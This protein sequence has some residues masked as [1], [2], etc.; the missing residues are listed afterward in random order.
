VAPRRIIAS[1]TPAS[2][3]AAAAAAPVDVSIIIPVLNKLEFTAQCLDRIWRNTDARITYEV[4]VVDN[5]STDGTQA[6]FADPSRFPRPSRYLRNSTN[7][8]FGPANNQGARQSTGRYLL[9]LNNDTLVQSGWLSEMLK[10]VRDDESVGI[11]GIKQLFPYTNEV[12]HTGIVFTPDR[13]PVHLYPH[14]DA[15]VAVVNKQREYQAVNGACLLVAR[16]LFDACGGFDEEYRNG[17]EDIDLCM[18]ARKQGRTIV[19]CTRA[20]IY[21]YGQITEGRTADDDQNAAIF[22]R[23]WGGEVVPDRDAYM[24]RDRG[25]GRAVFAAARAPALPGDAIYLADRLDQGSALTWVNAELAAALSDLGAPVFVSGERP[26]SKTLS[27]ELGHR[28]KRMT[29]REAPVGGV[30][31]KWSHYWPQHLNLDLAGD[32][33]L[34]LFVINYVFGRPGAE[35]WDYW[36]QTLRGTDSNIVS[37]SEFC[38]LVAG[39]AG[40]R[41]ERRHVWHP[42]YSPEIRDVARPATA[43]DRFRFLTVTNSH[44]LER[45]N[46]LAL[47]K[48]YAGAFTPADAVTLVV[49]DYGATSSDRRL[50]QAIARHP[51][52]AAIEYVTAFTSKRD[53]IAL[54]RSCD[55]FVSA[56]RGEGFGM[57]ILDALAC[58]L[59]VIT[60]LFGGP[61]AYC[62]TDNCFA[63]DFAK[64]PVGDCLDTRSL[65]ITNQPLWAEVDV[66]SL[67]LQLLRVYRDGALRAAVARRGHD[68]V[69]DAFSWPSAAKR[70]MDIAALVRKRT[71]VVSTRAAERPAAAPTERSPYWQG[72]R[73]SVVVP[74]HNRKDKLLACLDALGRQSVLPQEYEVIVVD[75]GS[76]DGTGEAIRSR[77]FPFTFRYLRQEQSGPA[78]A[79]NLGVQTAEGELVLFIGDDIVADETLIEEHL[80]AHAEESRE[81]GL[82]ILGHIDWPPWMSPNALMQYVCGESTLQF[83]FPLISQ[84]R[85][86]DHRFFYTSNIS[87]RRTFLVDAAAAGIVFDRA[88]RH[89]AFEDSEFA[90]RLTPR[91]LRIRYAPRARVWHD[92]WMDLESFA[93]REFRAGQ[94]AVVFYRKHPG[95]EEHVRV[96]WIA[97]LVRDAAALP[98]EPD[99]LASLRKLDAETDVVLH[100]LAGAYDA[101]LAIAAGSEA[102][103]IRGLSADRLRAGLHRMFG[104]IFDVQRTRGKVLEWYSNVEDQHVIEAAQVLAAVQRKVEFLESSGAGIAEAGLGTADAGLVAGLRARLTERASRTVVDAGRRFRPADAARRLIA[105]PALLESLIR[106]DRF[107]QARLQR[108][109][110]SGWLKAYLDLRTRIRRRLV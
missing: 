104:V 49:K 74:T 16:D 65:H 7:R 106:A 72:L 82:A 5:A 58:G 66:A 86:L 19:C 33:N 2:L 100:S 94:M 81:A 44:D 43:R 41:Q 90:L 32:V 50:Q 34:A 25:D 39:Q 63:V 53:L 76:V 26:L 92:H 107:V 28:L 45:Y 97:D 31:V 22:Q 105:R 14:L 36:L 37:L 59:P 71:G 13:Q 56:H 1:L 77:T 62:R 67:R 17:Y 98:A 3:T 47:L 52:A 61:T 35:P 46:T 96:R 38:S 69:V 54:Y 64:V 91:G 11:V 51:D 95:H 18:K 110:R 4:V 24:A 87:L 84:L 10:I 108:P 75:D 9:F 8:G 80:I 40:V 12:Y 55:A 15:S 73:M 109:A 79:R 30:Q 78:A 6:W 21:H 20:F 99:L 89:A 42:G 88:F 85:S 102:G 23:K 68:T 29:L 70:F 101:L 83:A 60:P 57:K 93:N 27:S 103:P 48:A